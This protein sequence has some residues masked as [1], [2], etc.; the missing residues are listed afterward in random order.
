V[1]V[2][3]K[4]RDDH[5]KI[6]PDLREAKLN[7]LDLFDANFRQTDLSRADLSYS[8]LDA[9]FT[10]ASLKFA[11]LTGARIECAD[12][13]GA[14]FVGTILSYLDFSSATGLEITS[15]F[16]PPSISIETIY[17]PREK[18]LK[19]FSV[20]QVFPKT[21]LHTSRH[22]SANQFS[23]IL[24]SLAIQAKINSL[25]IDSMPIYDPAEYAAG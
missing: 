15:H 25:P 20:E 18:S 5:P 19:C 6:K 23:S 16:G 9:D 24:A 21:L 11:N 17:R 22:L 7:G 3:N 1:E 12:F 10:A 8:N 4:W 2:W 13:L 14:I